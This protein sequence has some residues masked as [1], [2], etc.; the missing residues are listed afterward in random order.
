M[1]ISPRIKILIGLATAWFVLYPFLHVALSLATMT[2]MVLASE[3]LLPVILNP[4]FL[5][6]LFLFQCLA[7]LIL[8][9]LQAFYLTHVIKNRNSNDTTRIILGLGVF[10]MPFVAMPV[11]F[12]LFIWRDEPPEWTLAAE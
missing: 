2:G 6:T 7:M 11:Y 9:A 5:V 10:F 12:Y 3:E 8:F 4:V 1:Y